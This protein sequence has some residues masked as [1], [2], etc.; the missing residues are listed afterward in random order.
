MDAP[1]LASVGASEALLTAVL[2]L[3]VVLIVQARATAG[4]LRRVRREVDLLNKGLAGMQS[5]R[6]TPA[7]GAGSEA[8]Q[9]TRLEA[10]IRKGDPTGAIAIDI[11]KRSISN[12][13]LS[14]SLSAQDLASLQYMCGP[15]ADVPVF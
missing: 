6:G 7:S 11:L 15:D 10:C 9:P 14:T 3:L 13:S 8:A 5:V 12:G 2:A 4:E 1:Y